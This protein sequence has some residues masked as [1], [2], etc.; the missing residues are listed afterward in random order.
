[1]SKLQISGLTLLLGISASAWAGGGPYPPSFE[2]A[3]SAFSKTRLQVIAELGQAQ[4][5]GLIS[6]GE[7]DAPAATPE[8]EQMIADAGNDADGHTSVAVEDAGMPLAEQEANTQ[9]ASAVVVW[10][11]PRK[12]RAKIAAEAREA[13]RLGLLAFGE[14][15]APVATDEQEQLIA[16]AGRRAVEDLR[17]ADSVAM[18]TAR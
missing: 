1:M 17:F 4:R 16:K 5:L 3:S 14:G 18:N 9:M 7:S 8:Q 10:G 13:N 12:L 15:D 6:V 2:Y 11:D